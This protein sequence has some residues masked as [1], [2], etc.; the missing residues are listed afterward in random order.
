MR[1]PVAKS[2][3]AE[4]WP[5]DR[6]R[7]SPRNP[8]RHGNEQIAQI[9][10]SIKAY[11]FNNPLLIEPSGEIIAGEARWHAAQRCGLAELPVIVLAHLTP[12]Q[13]EAYR[14]AD[15]R[16]ALEAT[17]DDALLAGV[18]EDLKA[19][20]EDLAP[21]G[22]SDDELATLLEPAG[23]P[24]DGRADMAAAPPTEPV[25]R[26]GD[27]WQL[28]PHRLICGDSTK[29]AT[30]E[31][32]FGPERARLVLTDPP[33]GMGYDQRL[34]AADLVVTDP[35]YGM[36]YDGGRALAHMVVTD[37]PYGMSFGAGKE[38]GSTAK[39][40]KVKAH[41]VI[42]GDQARGDELVALVRDALAAGLTFCRP[43]AA[44]YVCLT[45]RTYGEFARALSLAGLA[46]AACIVWDKGSIGL[47]FQHYR[48]QHEFIFY[49]RGAAW[50]GGNAESDV[51]EISRGA[52]GEYVH[53]TQKPV[54]LLERA[55]RNSSRAGDVVLDLFGGSG[56][57][58]IA[59]ERTSRIARLVELDPKYCD[60]I[61]RRWETFTGR[62]A[63]R[64]A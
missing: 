54:A 49:C 17:W 61:V 10:R 55:I 24:D 14:V 51:W 44:A 26:A 36:A 16:L 31:R 42:L 63:E 7:P 62:T 25:T 13:R 27:L 41:G 21:I 32:L 23:A 11:G 18:L 19:G 59:C 30:L 57:T 1:A 40:A 47:G 64:A 2:F 56:S 60:A 29:R 28:G 9:A 15:N 37:P 12:L 8:R 22:F 53:P 50:F 3:T 48:G 6:L 35:P 4:L 34:H 45:W 38:A 58:L 5:A 33:Y 20:G 52:T 39:G 46:I 43:G